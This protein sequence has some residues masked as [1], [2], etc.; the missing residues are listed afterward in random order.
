MR[1]G[2]SFLCVLCLLCGGSAA[3]F[4]QFQMPDPKQMSGIPR[5]VT[6]LPDRAIS[7][8]LIRG[9]LSNNITDFPVEL[10]IGSKVQTVKTDDGGRAQFNDVPPGATVRALAVVDGER[11]ESQE[12]QA[13]ER[14]GVRLM[15]VATDKAGKT[16]EDASSAGVSGQVAISGQSRI[17]LEPADEALT[18][19][20]LLEIVN[21]A[22]APV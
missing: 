7:V 22:R 12:F 15:L 3:V 4:G 11:L 5:P 20:Y 19:Y 21:N 6:D 18:V 14:G 9:A 2:L 16:G 1:I 17:I 10:H 8:R 13:P